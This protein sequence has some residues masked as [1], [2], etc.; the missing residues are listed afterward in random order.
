MA[1]NSNRAYNYQYDSSARAYAAEPLR[2]PLPQ[3]E[4]NKKGKI[5]KSRKLD[6]AFCMQISICGIAVFASAFIYVNSYAELR[7]SQS[8][9][10]ELKSEMI[11]LKSDINDVEAKIASKLNLSNISKRAESELGMQEPL[12]H[13]IVYFELPEESYT[14]YEK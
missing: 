13:Q 9:L 1:N 7:K 12:P 6:K 3:K 4:P 14:S 5:K 2:K 11:Q 8:E 10:I